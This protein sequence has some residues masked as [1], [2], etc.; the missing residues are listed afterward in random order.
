MILDEVDGDGLEQPGELAPPSGFTA[1]YDPDTRNLAVLADTCR[2]LGPAAMRSPRRG[3]P[4]WRN[5]SAHT[6]QELDWKP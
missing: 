1:T 3:T 4:C 6:A 5:R 2:S